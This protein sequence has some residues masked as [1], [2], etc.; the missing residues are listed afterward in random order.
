MVSLSG[1]GDRPFSVVFRSYSPGDAPVRVENLCEDLFLKIHQ[2]HLGQ[3][4]YDTLTS[5]VE[6]NY[7]IFLFNT[8]S[9]IL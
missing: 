3:V 9:F 8:F 6:N 7:Y 2:Q 5:F 4:T 1:G